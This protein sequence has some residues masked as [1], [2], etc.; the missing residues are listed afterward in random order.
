MLVA[1]VLGTTGYQALWGDRSPPDIRV[2]IESVSRRDEGYLV[3]FTAVNRGGSPA[4]GVVIEARAGERAAAERSQTTLD[5]LPAHS[6]R[7]GGLYV[8][9]DPSRPGFS[10]RALGYE[11]P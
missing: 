10:I 3:Q 6:R 11:R 4:E 1:L 7:R 5:Y 9:T 2:E 8:S